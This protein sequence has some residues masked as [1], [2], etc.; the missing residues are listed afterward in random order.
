MLD[1]SFVG[2]CLHQLPPQ[3][4]VRALWMSSVVELEMAC[5][6]FASKFTTILF[7]N[8]LPVVFFDL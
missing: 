7:A 4:L 5:G 2:Q 1:V 3:I 8:F 6:Q